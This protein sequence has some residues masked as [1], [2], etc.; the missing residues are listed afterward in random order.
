ML[1][2]TGGSDVSLHEVQGAASIIREAAHED[3]HIIFGAV[4]DDKFKDQLRVTA[5]AT[6]F[7][8]RESDVRGTREVE[9]LER[10]QKE[11]RRFDMTAG[12]VS[13]HDESDERRLDVPAFT[14]RK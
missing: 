8:S 10:G 14:R 1:N 2:V 3:A 6:G 11:R 9:N 13:T 7:G 5:I 4:T 12:N